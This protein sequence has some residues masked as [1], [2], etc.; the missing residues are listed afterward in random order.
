L[1]VQL[2]QDL[3]RKIY[4]FTQFWFEW[5]CWIYV[6]NP[7][8]CKSGNSLPT[9]SSLSSSVLSVCV[10]QSATW[11]RSNHELTCATN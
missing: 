5:G 11:I 7:K 2:F 4:Q 1:L 8:L 3:R 10:T 6:V 9:L